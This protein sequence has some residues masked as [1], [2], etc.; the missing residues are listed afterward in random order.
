MDPPGGR[1]SRAGTLINAVPLNL[2]KADAT[3]G[4][5]DG[6]VCFRQGRMPDV[7]DGGAGPPRPQGPGRAPHRIAMGKHIEASRF[8]RDDDGGGDIGW[9]SSRCQQCLTYSMAA[10]LAVWA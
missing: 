10:A 8:D 2:R 6:L 1:A 4:L 7:P 5:P 9:R 3:D